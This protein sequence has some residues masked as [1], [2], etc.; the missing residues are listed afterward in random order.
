MDIHGL[1][2]RQ[3]SRNDKRQ[4]D[5]DARALSTQKLLNEMV[6]AGCTHAVVE[7]SSQGVAQFRHVGIAYDVMVLTN[8]AP[9]YRSA[10]GFEN[11]KAAKLKAF[12]TL[13]GSPEG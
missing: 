3:G 1:M 2:A 10:W 11:Y 6:R 8:L 4:K 7:T 13:A 12:Q 5:D 9:T